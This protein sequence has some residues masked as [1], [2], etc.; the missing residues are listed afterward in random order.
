MLTRVCFSLAFASALFTTHVRAA[1]L[2]FLCAAALKPVMD[3]LIPI[4]EQESGHKVNAAYATIGGT[5][6]RVQKGDAADLVVVSPAQTDELQ[7]AGKA[8][9]PAVIA[10]VG[11]AIFVKKGAPKP[12]ISTVEAFKKAVMDAKGISVSLAQGSG[13]GEY[14]LALFDRLGMSEVVKAKNKGTSSAYV[15]FVLDGSADFGFTQ[16]SI[17]VTYPPIEVVGPL[18]KEIQNYTVFTASVP[19]Q[20]KEPAAA[21]A[22]MQFLTSPKAAAVLK[23]RGLEQD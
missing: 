19:A 6:E 7:K 15:Q 3:D 21:K 1:E 10:K 14:M 8:H 22:L 16:M 18:P 20:A 17:A 12:D 2:N 23:T 5:V 9:D 4:F 13:A 11:V